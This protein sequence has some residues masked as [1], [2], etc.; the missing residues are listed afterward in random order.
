[1]YYIFQVLALPAV[2]A[3]EVEKLRQHK[4]SEHSTEFRNLLQS[5]KGLNEALA[6]LEQQAQR[7]FKHYTF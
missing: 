2:Y 6:Q 3:E 1:M 7:I 4:I 5:Q